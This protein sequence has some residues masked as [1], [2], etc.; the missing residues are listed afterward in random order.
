MG[1]DCRHPLQ[2]SNV[3]IACRH[4]LQASNVGILCRHQRSRDTGIHISIMFTLDHYACRTLLTNGVH[5]NPRA[6]A[7]DAAST[8]NWSLTSLAPIVMTVLVA[9]PWV[10][11]LVRPKRYPI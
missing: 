11:V 7:V 2:A 10:E 1:I 4:P 9:S 8:V 3:G 5:R 6:L